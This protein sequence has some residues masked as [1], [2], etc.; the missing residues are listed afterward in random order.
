[1]NVLDNRTLEITIDAPKRYFP[2]KLTYPVAYVLD[3]EN[4]ESG[5]RHW[6]DN[7]NGTGPFKLREYRIE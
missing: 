7:P 4:V 1:M 3:R 6:F 2:A 5:G